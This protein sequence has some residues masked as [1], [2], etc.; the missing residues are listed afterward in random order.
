MYN[1]GISTSG[2]LLDLAVD[3]EIVAKRGS[4]YTYGDVR[5]GQGRENAKTYLEQNPNLAAELDA[6][7]RSHF[8]LAGNFAPKEILDLDVALD[9]AEA[10]VLAQAA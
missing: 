2:D 9:D 7:V 4:F 5:L 3:L 10:E 1:Q 6:A 8:G